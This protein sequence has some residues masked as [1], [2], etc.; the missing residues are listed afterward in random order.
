MRATVVD[1]GQAAITAMAEAA[2]SGSRIDVVLLDANMPDIDGFTVAGEISR[3]RPQLSNTT[4][5]MLSSA[6]QY[7]DVGRCRDLGIAAYLTQTGVAARSAGRDRQR[8]RT[9]HS[10]VRRT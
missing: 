2:R 10:R 5:I 7:G 9:N 1:G 6:G 4:I 8:A 3:L